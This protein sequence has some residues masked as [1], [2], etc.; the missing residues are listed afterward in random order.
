ML[1][2][3]EIH[4]SR[5]D[6]VAAETRLRGPLFGLI[7]EPLWQVRWCQVDDPAIQSVSTLRPGEE[8]GS[9]E[10]AGQR[11]EYVVRWRRDL[12]RRP[13]YDPLANGEG[14]CVTPAAVLGLGDALPQQDS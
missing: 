5:T 8:S 9:A 14:N 13:G 10:V 12:R 3:P 6:I 1:A 2:I 11:F 7:G 4:I